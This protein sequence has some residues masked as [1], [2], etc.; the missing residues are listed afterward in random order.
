MC[1]LSVGL[2][3]LLV[4]GFDFGALNFLLFWLVCSGTV[5]DACFVSSRFCLPAFHLFTFYCPMN[6]LSCQKLEEKVRVDE[7][8]IK[9][10]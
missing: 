7:E 2:V 1:T 8:E 6:K 4:K 10:A 9:V 5:Y 3:F